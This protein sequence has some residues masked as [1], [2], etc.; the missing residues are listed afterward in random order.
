MAVALTR[1]LLGL[2]KV[3]YF[4][5]ALVYAVNL[6]LIGHFISLYIVPQEVVRVPPVKRS[7]GAQ[8]HLA[9]IKQKKRFNP[10]NILQRRINLPELR[11]R[12]GKLDFSK[13]KVYSLPGKRTDPLPAGSNEYWLAAAG[14][15]P[16]SAG[17][18][19]ELDGRD[20]QRRLKF[21]QSR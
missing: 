13:F 20:I 7:K 4:I 9:A 18:I 19:R 10:G 12:L 21:E 6:Y 16:I 11:G 2:F 3:Y 8:V 15:Q 17:P 14:Q 1:S 5:Y